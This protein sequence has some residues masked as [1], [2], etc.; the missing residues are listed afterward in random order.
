[1][2]FTVYSTKTYRASFEKLDNRHQKAVNI[3]IDLWMSNPKADSLYFKKLSFQGENIFSIRGT[4][5]TRVIIA[6][7]DGD[8]Y[9]LQT[10]HQHDKINDWAKNKKISRNKMTGVIQLY[11]DN[12]E[13]IVAAEQKKQADTTEATIFGKYSRADLLEIGV[14]EECVDGVLSV[15]NEEQFLLIWDLLPEE[16]L[17][18][19]NGL[20]TGKVTMDVL[21]SQVRYARKQ[22]EQSNEKQVLRATP[23]LI[24]YG[25]DKQL[26]KAMEEDINVFRFYLHPTQYRFSYGHFNGPVKLTG[27]AGTGKTV[28]ALRRAKYLLEQL[29]ENA[30]PILFTTFTQAL[31]R[32]IRSTFKGQNLSEE[33]LKVE[34]LHTY[35]KNLSKEMEIFPDNMRVLYDKAEINSYWRDFTKAQAIDAYTADFLQEEYEQVIQEQHVCSLEDYLEVKRVG[36]GQGLNAAARKDLWRIFQ[37]YENQVFK[38]LKMPMRDLL[39]RLTRELLEN[40]QEERPFSHIIC[41]EVQDLSNLELRLLRAMVPEGPNDL[42]LTGDPFQ[43]IYSRKINFSQAGINIRGSRSRRLTLN[44]RTTEQIRSF[45]VDMLSGHEFMDFNGGAADISG[46]RSKLT[47]D[48]PQ[49]YHFDQQEEEMNFIL[50]FL[51]DSFGT[52]HMHEVCITAMRKNEIDAIEKFLQAHKISTVR[53]ENVEDL[54]KTGGK[55]ILG[56]MHKLKGLEFK[57]LIV[58]GLQGNS[59]PYLPQRYHTASEAEKQ[60]ILRAVHALYYVA[61]S[62]TMSQLILTGFGEPVE[63]LM[64]YRKEGSLEA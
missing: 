5:S 13:E 2:N 7:L 23:G 15:R 29:P 50:Q 19:L 20:M 35:A 57:N 22:L 52:L 11:S 48:E 34:S 40:P 12:I 14:P 49:Y 6:K 64:P 61:F 51:K 28:V 59:F 42:F 24:V 62:R 39:F 31:V 37:K 44:Y 54:S 30:A 38:H 8:Y 33:R 43:N 32:N 55:V 27:G 21:L 9:L 36:R 1:M 41:D 25:Q 63:G 16:I 45:A 46:D 4:L 17:Q 3:A 47:G 53:L 60:Q 18:C 10:S 56:N 58:T 26:I